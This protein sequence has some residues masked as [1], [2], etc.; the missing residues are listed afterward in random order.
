MDINSFLSIGIIGV[1]FSLG[2]EGL[3]QTFGITGNWTK[4]IA[5]V[6]SIIIA[7][8]FVLFSSAAWWT[9]VLGILGAASTTYAMFFSSA[10]S[11]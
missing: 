1:L 8:V 9:T 10:P 6:G 2:I 11:K 7:T 4:F 5:I 3:Q